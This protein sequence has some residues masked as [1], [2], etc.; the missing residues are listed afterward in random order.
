MIDRSISTAKRE[1]CPDA[2]FD[3]AACICDGVGDG[4][5]EVGVGGEGDVGGYGCW[6]GVRGCG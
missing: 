5:A 1:A 4:D 6:R 3:V 2:G